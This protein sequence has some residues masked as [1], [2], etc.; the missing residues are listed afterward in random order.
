[1]STGRVLWIIWCC[2]WAGVWSVALWLS[3]YADGW[4]GG[5]FTAG[6]IVSAAAIG[7][8]VGSARPGWIRRWWSG[9]PPAGVPSWSE[10]VVHRD[11]EQ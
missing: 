4:Y 9:K 8:P 1:M 7:L 11:E 3:A 2:W 10:L 5:W 6:I